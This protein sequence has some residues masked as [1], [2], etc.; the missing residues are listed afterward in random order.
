MPTNLPS[1]HEPESSNL[2]GLGADAWA[3]IA[4]IFAMFIVGVIYWSGH[5]NDAHATDASVS[6]TTATKSSRTTVQ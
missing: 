1:S 2:N 5:T 4:V 6:Q 3:G